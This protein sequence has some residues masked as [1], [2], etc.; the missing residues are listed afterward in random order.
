V[1]RGALF[2]AQPEILVNLVHADKDWLWPMFLGHYV[3]GAHLVGGALLAIGL[4]SRLAAAVQ[5]PVLLGALLFVHGSEGLLAVGQSLE[6]VAL[7]LVLLVTYSV[8]GSGRLSVDYYL[9]NQPAEA[10]ANKALEPSLS[11]VT[12]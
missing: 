5:V 4:A 12:R 8:Y 1:V 7:V 6:L 11:G 10:E 2:V 3:A 9:A